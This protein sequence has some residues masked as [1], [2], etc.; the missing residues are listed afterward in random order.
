FDS[1]VA[2]DTYSSRYLGKHLAMG[3]DWLDGYAGFKPDFQAEVRAMLVRWSDFIRDNGYYA[4]SP[5]SNYGAGSYVSRVMTALAL[6]RRHP[7]G[8]RLLAEVV[9]WR[10]KYVLPALTDDTASL[11]GGFWP[12]GWSYGVLAAQNLLL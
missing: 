12:E 8:P 11:K 10:H 6:A 2:D 4:N 5:A 3:L 1:I 7:A 9:A